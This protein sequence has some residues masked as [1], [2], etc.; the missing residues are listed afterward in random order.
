MAALGI[1]LAEHLEF[2]RDYAAQIIRNAKA[3]GQ[4][5]HDRG[6]TVLAER[7]GV[8]ES[9][10]LAIDVS[11]IGG[12][13]EVSLELE[14]ANIVTN[15]NLLPWDASSVKP[16]G[17]RVGTQELTRLGM[18]E[19]QMAEVAGLSAPAVP[20]LSVGR[21]QERERVERG[22]AVHAQEPPAHDD[23]PAGRDRHDRVE[24]VLALH[25]G[26]RVVTRGGLPQVD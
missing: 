7:H 24:V 8:T 26:G 2:G 20:P 13:A 11:A 4:A 25:L 14:R 16:S 15:K 10:A 9:H 23:G 1:T 22:R 19:A 5:L 3:L 17:V 12:G 18:R 6:F 21:S